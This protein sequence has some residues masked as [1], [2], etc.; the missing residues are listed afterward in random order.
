ML[1]KKAVAYKQG[2]SQGKKEGMR[3]AMA[4]AAETRKMGTKAKNLQ[5][6]LT[7]LKDKSKTFNEF[8]TKAIELIDGRMKEI[9]RLPSPAPKLQQWLRPSD[10]RTKPAERR[11]RSRVW[12]LCKP[13]STKSLSSL[14][15]ETLRPRCSDT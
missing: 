9:Q 2:R 3:V 5:K 4:N 10:R 13:S 1:F 11:L 6:A 12:R 7:Q 14:I 15:R 8:L